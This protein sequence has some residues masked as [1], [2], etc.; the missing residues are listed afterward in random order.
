MHF[1]VENNVRT[2]VSRPITESAT[3]IYINKATAPLNDPPTP[4]VGKTVRLTLVY[5]SDSETRIELV[6]VISI[7]D[8]NALE[9]RLEVVRAREDTSLQSYAFPVG[10][11]IFLANTA[12]AIEN[13]ADKQQVILIEKVRVDANGLPD[14]NGPFEKIITFDSQGN[15]ITIFS[16]TVV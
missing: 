3:T 13:K 14:V 8:E 15:P 9:W 2:T 1:L 10:S 12:E 4:E 11:T 7:T 6:D 16:Q 5:S